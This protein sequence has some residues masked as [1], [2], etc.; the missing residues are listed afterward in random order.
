MQ[1]WW[2]PAYH[3]T[4]DPGDID[5]V[6]A[7]GHIGGWVILVTRASVQ[8]GKADVQDVLF[9]L[10][11]EKLYSEARVLSCQALP[12]PHLICPSCLYH[13]IQLPLGTLK[14]LLQRATVEPEIQPSHGFL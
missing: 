11:P 4:D 13:W 12:Q 9:K 2:W 10:P 5:W 6:V 3:G 8:D 1:G 14:I 7:V